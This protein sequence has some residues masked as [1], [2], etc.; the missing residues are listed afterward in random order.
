MRGTKGPVTNYIAI[1]ITTYKDLEQGTVSHA[2]LSHQTFF[3]C[4]FILLSCISMIFF[5]IMLKKID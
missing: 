2:H 4:N 1:T 5:L 3:I